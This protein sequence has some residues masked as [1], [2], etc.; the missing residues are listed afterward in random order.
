MEVE[1]K[2]QDGM[3]EVN[4]ENLTSMASTFNQPLEEIAQVS[5]CDE[6]TLG[7]PT[8]DSHMSEIEDHVDMMGADLKTI[9]LLLQSN[10]LSNSSAMRVTQPNPWR[11][12]SPM[13]QGRQRIAHVHQCQGLR[14]GME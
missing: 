6:S 3:M 13:R 10:G 4:T 11:S 8:T 14:E 2:S 12:V 5:R 1:T 9:L 7:N